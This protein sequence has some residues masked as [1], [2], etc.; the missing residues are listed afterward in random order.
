MRPTAL[1]VTS[2]HWPDD[3]RIRERLIRTLSDEFDVIYATRAPG[4]SDP[5]DLDYI[6]LRGGRPRRILEA[7]TR[8]L[9]LDWDVL[10]VHDPELV[11]GAALARMIKRR[12][13]VFDVHEDFPAVAH[14]RAWV[15]KPLR[16]LLAGLARFGMRIAEGAV[17]ITLAEHG[18]RH[19][20]ARDHPV[21]PNLPNTST[22]PPVQAERSEEAVYLGDATSQRGV[23]VAVEAC[24]LAGLPLRLI[25][26][27]APDVA[28][29]T[30]ASP[31]V[32]IEG[33]LPN[34]R[35]IEL[36]SRALVGLVPLRDLPN[37]RHS[38]PTKL[39]EYL[40]VGVPVV[41]TDL[42]G[43]RALVEG[44]AAVWLVPPDDPEAMARA[45][46]EARSEGA[47]QTAS[48]QALSIRDRFRWPAGEVA[49]FYRSLVSPRESPSPT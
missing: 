9:R 46:S 14:T 34:P 22:Y 19:L 39:L 35:A 17:A 33:E 40:A 24:S 37:Y 36:A 32:I 21:F 47:R 49:T 44:L 23:D 38:Q 28:A 42:P 25:G 7:L 30:T 27:V 3:T 20:F 43:T 6:E 13:V 26:R 1:V 18:Y 16:G 8:M 29:I 45:I 48:G 12:P 11:P 2:V 4:P 15:P 10:V 5:T 41:A 31:D